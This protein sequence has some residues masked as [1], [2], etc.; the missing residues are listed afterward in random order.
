VT[1]SG[2]I[3]DGEPLVPA[4]ARGG[5]LQ[6]GVGSG[7]HLVIDTGFAGAVAVPEDVARELRLDY[8]GVGTFI[9]AMGRPVELPVYAGIIRVGRRRKRTWFILGEGLLGME[10]LDEISVELRLSFERQEVE[11]RLR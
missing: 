5:A 10:F 4:R 7:D 2:V 6:I 9:L 1:L 8:L 3:R 11:I